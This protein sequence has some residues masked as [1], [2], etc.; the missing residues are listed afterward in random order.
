MWTVTAGAVAT[1]AE[2]LRGGSGEAMFAV[3]A[4]VAADAIVAVVAIVAIV[5]ADA[6]V[7]AWLRLAR[8]PPQRSALSAPA[9]ATATAAPV[10]R[11]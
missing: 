4:I 6:L 10:R 5:A 7:T 3:V 9:T 1:A 8:A 2:P 11:A